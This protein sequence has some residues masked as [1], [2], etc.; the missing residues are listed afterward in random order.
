VYIIG[1]KLLS[2]KGLYQIRNY[3]GAYWFESKDLT[4]LE[5]T[6]KAYSTP[7]NIDDIQ[8]IYGFLSLCFSGAIENRNYTFYVGINKNNALWSVAPF[9]NDNAFTT[10]FLVKINKTDTESTVTLYLEKLCV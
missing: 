9:E 5:K 10:I 6:F 1:E 8:S 4:K 3:I 2:L 7:Q